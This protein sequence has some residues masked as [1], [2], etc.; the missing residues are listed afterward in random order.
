[1]LRPRL[2]ILRWKI[3]L[4]YR[5]QGIRELR[6]HPALL[7]DVAAKWQWFAVLFIGAVS[8]LAIGEYGFGLFLLF[9]SAVSAASKIQHCAGM[10]SE[11]WT[12]GWRTLNALGRR[13]VPHPRVLPFIFAAA[14]F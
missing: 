3:K 9:L 10:Q 8:V 7:W 13:W 6:K 2:P 11:V 4:H 14:W 5:V 12:G 1:M